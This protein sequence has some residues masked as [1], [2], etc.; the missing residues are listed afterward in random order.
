MSDTASFNP[1][2][3]DLVWSSP[4]RCPFTQEWHHTDRHHILGRG[5][6]HNRK[7]MS[8]IY[9]CIPLQPRLHASGWHRHP[10]FTALCLVIAKTK[11]QD[12]IIRGNYQPT[13][14]DASFLEYTEQWHLQNF[15]S[16]YEQA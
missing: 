8:S 16:Q 7:M 1:E 3:V 15:P 5:G 2:H 6:K 9:N 14:N 13:D 12:A 10:Y 11:V 4:Q